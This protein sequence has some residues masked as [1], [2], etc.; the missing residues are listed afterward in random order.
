MNKLKKLYR[1][2][3]IG[4]ITGLPLLTA[5]E[6]AEVLQPEACFTMKRDSAGVQTELAEGGFIY[7]GE[8]IVFTDCGSFDYGTLYSGLP[9]RVYGSSSAEEP[10]YGVSFPTRGSLPVTYPA[11]GTYTATLIAVNYAGKEPQRA[12]KQVEI[13]VLQ[14]P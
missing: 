7:E 9:G 6:E 3:V 14:K 2:L 11:A 12:F 8:S 4:F 1:L 5:C 10:N 13:R